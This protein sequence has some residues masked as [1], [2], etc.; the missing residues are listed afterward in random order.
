MYLN[1]LRGLAE[2]D[3]WGSGWKLTGDYIGPADQL[4]SSRAASDAPP[5][6]NTDWIALGTT[7]LTTWGNMKNAEL[8]SKTAIAVAPYQAPFRR[9]GMP[10]VTPSP[11]YGVSPAVAIPG[12]NYAPLLLLAAIG[13]AAY[14][15]LKG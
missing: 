2:G 6:N 1:G 10:G 4:Y 12:T 3:E 7:A 8:Q 14:L 11:Y 13:V 9:Y 15:I 5:T